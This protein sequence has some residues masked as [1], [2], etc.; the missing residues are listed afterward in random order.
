MCPAVL[1]LF[2]KLQRLFF[3]LNLESLGR[4]VGRKLPHE[5]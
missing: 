1:V 4:D 3:N 2:G 5:L